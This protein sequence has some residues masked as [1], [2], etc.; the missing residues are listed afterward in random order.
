[1]DGGLI[2]SLSFGHSLHRQDKSQVHIFLK[3][4]LVSLSVQCKT[5]LPTPGSLPQ[6]LTAQAARV[7][8][9]RDSTQQL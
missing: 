8:A 3:G 1:M 2:A 9:V 5:S 6:R 7:A 4:F